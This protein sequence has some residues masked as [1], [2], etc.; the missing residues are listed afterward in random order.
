MKTP[1]LTDKQK[2]QIREK[3]RHEFPGSKVLQDLHY[4]RYAKEILWRTMSPGEVVDD[5]KRGAGE[6][7]K[8]MKKHMPV[9]K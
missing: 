9:L 6:I 3:V 7:K 2:L 4:Y 8:A 1:R 5:I